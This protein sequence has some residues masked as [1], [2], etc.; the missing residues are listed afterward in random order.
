MGS[1][2]VDYFPTSKEG[3]NS[4]SLSYDEILDKLCPDYMAMGMTYDEYWN[5]DPEMTKFFRKAYE[6]KRKQKNYELWM[7][8]KY[9]YE[10]LGCISPLFHD[11][12][13]DPKPIPYLSEPF[14]LSKK[15]AD[16]QKLREEEEHDKKTQANFRALVEKI[17]RSKM[18]GAQ[19]NGR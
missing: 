11:W 7:Q 3:E 16:E 6:L 12:V 2:R 1:G 8:G 4:P 17:N 5:G 14:P 9:I 19:N 10:A 15:E 13:K 18:K